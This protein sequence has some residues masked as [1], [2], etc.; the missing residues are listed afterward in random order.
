MLTLMISGVM[1]H[2]FNCYADTIMDWE[3]STKMGQMSGL[4]DDKGIE[5]AYMVA[6]LSSPS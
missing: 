1:R 3:A 2:Q 4:N 5:S 6:S